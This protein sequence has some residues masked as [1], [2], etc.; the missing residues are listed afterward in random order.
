MWDNSATPVVYFR[1]HFTISGVS[2]CDSVILKIA[3][4]D[5]M[6]V[7]INGTQ[8]INDHNAMVDLQTVDVAGLVTIGDNVVAIK[9]I[10]AG[11]CQRICMTITEVSGGGLTADAG[12]DVAICEGANTTLHATGGTDYTWNPSTGL[13]SITGS[14]VTA[15][16]TI[17]TTYTVTTTAGNCSSTATVVVTVNPL[18]KAGTVT[19]ASDTV[20][21]G[22]N[23]NLT[24]NGSAG[25]IQW[26]SSINGTAFT[27]I[28]GATQTTYSS[29]PVTQ[30]TWYRTMAT[31]TCGTDSSTA[32]KINALPVADAGVLNTVKDTICSGTLALL[33]LNGNAGAVQWQSSL[34]SLGGFANITGATGSSYSSI[35]NQTNY[36]RV[37]AS[38][39]NCGN[40]TSN[41]ATEFVVPSP[42]AAFSDS[43]RVN[44]VYFNSDSS[45]DADSYTWDFGDSTYSN[46]ANP[47]HLY[48]TS[49]IYYVCLFVR[50]NAGCNYTLCKNVPV[51][52]TG[53]KA[54]NK[55][56]EWSIYPNPFTKDIFIRVQS[57]CIVEVYDLAGRELISNTVNN[58]QV[59]DLSYLVPGMYYVRLKTNDVDLVKKIVKQ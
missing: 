8:V 50:N 57:K 54:I 28:N 46:K 49:G 20:C 3:V 52:F 21:E 27:S 17:T 15:S 5:D 10:D 9:G 14:T 34:S 24:S 25:A 33:N 55:S 41:V 26:Q 36:F 11:G 23:T 18:V 43:I 6:D 51:I 56:Y 13:N 45:M 4:D 35:L 16:P 29:S 42:V 30:T 2:S 32:K 39:G 59:I 12:P 58:P 7:Y 47:T 1:N 48:D 44:K 37:I 19:A 38:S 22:G 53:T 31:G 40:D